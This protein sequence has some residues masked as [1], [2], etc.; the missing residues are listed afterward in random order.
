MFVEKVNKIALSANFD[1]RIQT[2]DGVIS[3]PYGIAPG[4]FCRE[5][6]MRYPKI[7]K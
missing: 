4:I 1:K 2:P 7:R 6:L 3:C 5:E